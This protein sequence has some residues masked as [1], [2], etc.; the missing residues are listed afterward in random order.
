MFR[1]QE[2]LPIK[3]PLPVNNSCNSTIRTCLFQID[4]LNADDI[5]TPEAKEVEYVIRVVLYL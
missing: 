4:V 5:K 2:P 3:V 1:E